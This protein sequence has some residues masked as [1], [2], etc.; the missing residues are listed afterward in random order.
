[1]SLGMVLIP[2]R[3]FNS[4]EAVANDMYRTSRSSFPIDYLVLRALDRKGV[5]APYYYIEAVTVVPL[6]FE[7]EIPADPR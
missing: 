6:R 5:V 4:C 3:S 1:M 7:S 2:R